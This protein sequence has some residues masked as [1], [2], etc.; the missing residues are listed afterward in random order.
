[1]HIKQKTVKSA[2]FEFSLLH[3]VDWRHLPLVQNNFVYYVF[4]AIF[5]NFKW[6]TDF[7]H[8]TTYVLESDR[9]NNRC[10][11]PSHLRCIQHNSAVLTSVEAPW[12]W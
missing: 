7:Q 10:K 8:Y 3:D 1:M 4:S 5:G 6:F 11:L 12:H 9:Q 2:A